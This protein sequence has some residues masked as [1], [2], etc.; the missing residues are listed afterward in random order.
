[1]RLQFKA[2]AF[3]ATNTPHFAN[4]SNNIANLTLN[5]DGTFR[6]GVFEITGIANTGREQGDE[7]SF[8]LGLRLQF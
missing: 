4:P 2:E 6:Q 5:P 1:V 3:N 7:R 8:R